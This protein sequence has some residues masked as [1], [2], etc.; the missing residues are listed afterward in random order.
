MWLLAAAVITSALLLRSSVSIAI[1]TGGVEQDLSVEQPHVEIAAVETTVQTTAAPSTTQPEPSPCGRLLLD[2]WD[3]GQSLKVVLLSIATDGR[4]GNELF[5]VAA[6]LV[7]AHR[8]H[9]PVLLIRPT[10]K[11]QILHLPCLRS[12]LG[13]RRKAQ[14]ICGCNEE[15]L[16]EDRSS[17]CNRGRGCLDLLRS[18]KRVMDPGGAGTG[19][20]QDLAEWKDSPESFL[21]LLREAFQVDMPPM[22]KKVTMP[23]KEDLVIYFRCYRKTQIFDLRG[24]S[25]F[26]ASPPFAFFD[27][28]VQQH[29]QE[30]ADATL[31]VVADP[32]MR[33]HPT[34]QRLCH[35]LGANIFTSSD[36]AGKEAWL[37]DWVWL[38]EA[39]HLVLSPSTFVW[40]AAFL[41]E[42]VRI[43]V[44]IFPGLAVL[45]W[46]KL[47]VPHD[48]RYTF[49]DFW[50]NTSFHEGT[51]AKIR[52]QEYQRCKDE[53]C[54]VQHHREAIAQL[55]P[56]LL[57]LN[58]SQDRKSVV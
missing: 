15:M 11:R 34:V 44:P 49:F 12:S 7:H 53:T 41:G 8:N 31:W 6:A 4:F 40:W 28:A 30:F 35:E 22:K 32:S 48:A 18:Q 57:E 3:E 5:V 39:Q 58:H 10:Q 16:W 17:Q 38:R 46:C 36:Q 14:E 23:G 51:A 26:L 9:H 56:E 54:P 47:L 27:F 37:A 1:A 19:Y 52:C 33:S 29:R 50:S 13:L 45:P 2:H 55:F 20:H 25:A 21:P 42:A 24:G 43:Y